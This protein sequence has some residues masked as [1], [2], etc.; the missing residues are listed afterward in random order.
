MDSLDSTSLTFPAVTVGTAAA[1]QMI[2][3]TNAQNIDVVPDVALTGANAGDFAFDKGCATLY[4]SITCT[5]TVDGVVR[6]QH[7]S[8]GHNAQTFCLVKSA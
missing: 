3:V 5:I 4:A 6:D 8:D 1:G 7:D 2:T